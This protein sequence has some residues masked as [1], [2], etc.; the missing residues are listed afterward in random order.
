MVDDYAKKK[1][2]KLQDIEVNHKEKHNFEVRQ[3]RDTMEL[4]CDGDSSFDQIQGA[5]QGIANLFYFTDS[6]YGGV[7]KDLYYYRQHEWRVI[8]NIR[9]SDENGITKNLARPLNNTERNRLLDIDRDFFTSVIKKG[10]VDN[11]RIDLCEVIP[12]VEIGDDA[13]PVHSLISRIIVPKE[14]LAAARAL[15]EKYKFNVKN[16]VDFESALAGAEREAAY[17]QVYADTRFDRLRNVKRI[18]NDYLS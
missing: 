16:V 5:I 4:L 11:E 3:L 8:S 7:H 9:I 1:T 6:D 13:P 12:S 17:E 14:A 15:A 10:V 18:M 2:R